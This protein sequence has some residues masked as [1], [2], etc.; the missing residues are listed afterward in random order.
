MTKQLAWVGKASSN[1]L[2][3]AISLL[4][5]LFANGAPATQKCDCPC[6]KD[7][8]PPSIVESQPGQVTILWP[9]PDGF[10]AR[11][12]HSKAE[13][14]IDSATAGTV[15][16]DAPL[17][18]S[19]PSGPHKLAVKGKDGYDTQITVS[20]Q[21]PLYF[22]IIDKGLSELDAATALALLPGNGTQI[23]SGIG[24]IYFY[25]PK[26]GS[27]FGFLDQ[28]NTDLPVLLDGKRIG[29]FTHG[30][31]LVVK[32]PSG[33]HVLTLDMRWWT[34]GQLL[35]KKLVLGGDTTRYFHVEKRLDF[36]IYEDSPQEA[37]NLAKM[38]LRQ[39]EA[40]LQ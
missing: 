40:S 34:S 9:R 25:W 26:S 3:I 21:K 19:V 27:G 10:L 24:T 8:K 23:S 37:A 38:G 32:A 7:K 33:E 28:L 4:L 31:Y 35:E 18:I 15:D 29:V 17:I 22:Q 13:V 12:F 5:W 2:F 14:Q 20:A 36:H 39:R 6:A 1:R 16:F 30:D 11:A